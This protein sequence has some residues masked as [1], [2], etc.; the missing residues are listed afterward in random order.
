LEKEQKT[1]TTNVATVGDG[2]DSSNGS[3]STQHDPE[4]QLNDS[5]EQQACIYNTL[6]ALAGE[7]LHA[8]FLNVSVQCHY[9]YYDQVV[10]LFA[11]HMMEVTLQSQI[12]ALTHGLLAGYGLQSMTQ[13]VR[14]MS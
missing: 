14:L 1:A 12:V 6:A 10:H 2:N 7:A 4:D 5:N 9:K 11:L 13:A 3:E 8:T